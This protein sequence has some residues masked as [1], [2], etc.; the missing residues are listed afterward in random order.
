MRKNDMYFDTHKVKIYKDSYRPS[1]NLFH[2]FR[3]LFSVILVGHSPV[4]KASIH[5]NRK[6]R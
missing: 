1:P 3:S 2:F 4:G 5:Y 6:S